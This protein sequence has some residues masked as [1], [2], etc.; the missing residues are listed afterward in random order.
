MCI[1]MAM[2]NEQSEFSLEWYS[3]HHRKYGEIVGAY[4]QRSV[5]ASL[6][7][8]KAIR[9]H[10]LQLLEYVPD[11]WNRSV[12]VRARD[13]K[14][15]RDS[16][17][18]RGQDAGGPCVPSYRPNPWDLA[19]SDVAPN[20][21]MQLTRCSVHAGRWAPRAPLR[22]QLDAHP[23]RRK[24]LFCVARSQPY[25][26]TSVGEVLRLMIARSPLSSRTVRPQRH[27]HETL[28]PSPVSIGFARSRRRLA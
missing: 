15:E 12:A 1:K 6:S 11:A 10:I 23:V 24:G 26:C 14:I 25:V 28:V 27:R 19:G 21:R 16:S 20:K 18:V 9:N 13:G 8:F 3:A 17:G 22:V 5:D 4:S 7:L 2:G